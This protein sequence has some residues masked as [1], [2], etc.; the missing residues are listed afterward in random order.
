M[1]QIEII[2]H[3]NFKSWFCA[4]K[5]IKTINTAHTVLRVPQYRHT[6]SEFV[7]PKM[8]GVGQHTVYQLSNG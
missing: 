6:K 3:C 8:W 1:I 4:A 5:D 2:E 7:Q